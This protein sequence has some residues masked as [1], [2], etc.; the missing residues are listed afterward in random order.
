MIQHECPHPAG[1]FALCECRREPMHV[2][3]SGRSKAE[4]HDKPIDFTAPAV[5]HALECRHCGRATTRHPTLDAAIA[6]WGAAYAQ[7]PLPLRVVAQRRR[8]A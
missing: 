3:I 7:S 8:A 6:E 1:T 5:R 2:E 4:A